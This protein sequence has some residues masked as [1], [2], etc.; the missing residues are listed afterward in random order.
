M[1]TRRAASNTAALS[2]SRPVSQRSADFVKRR[3]AS[4]SGAESFSERNATVRESAECERF[5]FEGLKGMELEANSLTRMTEA[6]QPAASATEK[7]SSKKYLR[8][9]TA[10][11][12]EQAEYRFHEPA[13]GSGRSRA[14]SQLARTA[15]LQADAA[16]G[17]EPSLF[18][19]GLVGPFS[20]GKTVWVRLTRNRLFVT[21]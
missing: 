9:L 6:R 18:S 2:F 20:P 21:P 8:P 3:R 12:W 11:K 19:V 7:S 1:R 5:S 15:L 13:T 10:T 4:R 14:V 16:T 17:C